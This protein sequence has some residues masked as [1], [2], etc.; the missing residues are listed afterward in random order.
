MLELLNEDCQKKLTIELLKKV[1]E[2]VNLKMMDRVSTPYL[3]RV[4]AAKYCNIS[5]PTFDK[6]VRPNIRPIVLGDRVFYLKKD[7]ESFMLSQKI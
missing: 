5:G 2:I 6:Y 3:S 4:Q 1:D 7:L